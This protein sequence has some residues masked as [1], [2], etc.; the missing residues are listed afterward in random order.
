[1]TCV[2]A[3]KVQRCEAALQMVAL[4]TMPNVDLRVLNWIYHYKLTIKDKKR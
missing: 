1:M 4:I 3:K 2:N